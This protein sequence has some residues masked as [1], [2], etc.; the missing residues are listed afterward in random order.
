MIVIYIILSFIMIDPSVKPTGFFAN[1]QPLKAADLVANSKQRFHDAKSSIK[2]AST[3]R[4][5]EAPA[6]AVKKLLR[7]IGATGSIAAITA[8]TIAYSI[9]FVTWQV[10][11]TSSNQP[12]SASP[13]G[14]NFA[15]IMASYLIIVLPL[16]A[17]AIISAAR[18]IAS[19]KVF[20]RIGLLLLGGW[21]ASLV[22]FVSA[23]TVAVPD[24]AD[25]SKQHPNNPYFQLQINK[26]HVD[27][28]CINIP[29]HCNDKPFVKCFEDKPL[30][31]SGGIDYYC[32]D[33]NP[34]LSVPVTPA[35]P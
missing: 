32:P 15:L 11:R 4:H 6:T 7:I 13:G 28:L 26:G 9:L 14:V 2:S 16:L 5:L 30:Y 23:A 3:K 31:G 35:G 29:G 22:V 27:N 33:P 1:G 24:W 18:R 20:L 21:L 12:F 19:S 10:H 34:D 17:L 8:V 25:W